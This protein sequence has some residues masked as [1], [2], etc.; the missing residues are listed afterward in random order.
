MHRYGPLSSIC[1]AN[2]LSFKDALNTSL[3][4][5]KLDVTPRK[6]VQSL[7]DPVTRGVEVVKSEIIQS[8]IEYLLQKFDVDNESLSTLKPFLALNKPRD[9]EKVRVLLCPDMDPSLFSLEFG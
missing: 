7:Y 3:K 2:Q 1:P 5:I 6:R 4:C 9:I 8:L